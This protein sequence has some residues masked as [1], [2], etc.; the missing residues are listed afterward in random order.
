MIGNKQQILDFLS[1][2]DEESIFEL[3]KKQEKSIRSQAQNRY[4]HGIICSTISDWS[5]DDTISV[6]YM[7]KEMFKIETT[8]DLSTDE[9]AFMCKS[10]IELFKQNYNVRI[11]LPN[12]DQDLKNLEKYL[13]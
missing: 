11:P 1:K 6:H 5:W 8:T 4:W 3:T 12:E 2:Q 7:L 10:V 13:F 9:F